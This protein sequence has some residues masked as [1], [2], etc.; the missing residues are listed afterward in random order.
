MADCGAIMQQVNDL[1]A[2]I[3]SDTDQ[4]NDPHLCDNLTKPQCIALRNQLEDDRTAAQA[5]LDQVLPQVTPICS[6]LVGTWQVDAN[7]SDGQLTIDRVDSVTGQGLHGSM[8]VAGGS[9][10]TIDGSWDD[11]AKIIQF[12]LGRGN[13]VTQDYTGFLGNNSAIILAG[14]FTES[15]VLPGPGRYRFGWFARK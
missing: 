6:L 7:G 1:Q 13:P 11:A 4:L 2:R 3:Q 9:P 15:D 14:W 5:E 8:A 10:D 12:T